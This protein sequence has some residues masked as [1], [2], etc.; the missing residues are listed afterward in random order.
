MSERK[1]LREQQRVY[2]H[3]RGWDRLYTVY[4]LHLYHHLHALKEFSEHYYI[5][6]ELDEEMREP[7]A[8][9]VSFRPS[10]EI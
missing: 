4:Q 5:L 1:W 10:N 8:I 6:F 2:S 9:S 3:L 7:P